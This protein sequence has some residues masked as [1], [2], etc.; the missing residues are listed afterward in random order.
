FDNAVHNILAN[1]LLVRSTK[2]VA[3]F[4]GRIFSA[5]SSLMS[6]SQIISIA[7]GG[8][9]LAIWGPR[10]IIMSGSIAAAFALALTFRPVLE[11]GASELVA[12]EATTP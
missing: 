12:V 1:L 2:E 5:V 7:I 11:A 6:A 8:A 3:Q 10:T 4:R 9:L